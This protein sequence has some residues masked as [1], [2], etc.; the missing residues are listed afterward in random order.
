MWNNIFGC[1]MSRE[2][3]GGFRHYVIHHRFQECEAF[4]C[5]EGWGLGCFAA[6]LPSPPPRYADDGVL[7]TF[8]LDGDL[9]GRQVE[10]IFPQVAKNRFAVM[11]PS[12]TGV[13]SVFG[14]C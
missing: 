11:P 2:H 14:N 6:R 12:R 10:A 9:G 13:D 8:K 7:G 5:F 4:E 3:G 1:G